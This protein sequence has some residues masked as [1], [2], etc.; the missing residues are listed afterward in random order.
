MP[1]T[2]IKRPN[3]NTSKIKSVKEKPKIIYNKDKLK[4]FKE[5]LLSGSGFLKIH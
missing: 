5:K 3:L 4:E 2:L 1:K